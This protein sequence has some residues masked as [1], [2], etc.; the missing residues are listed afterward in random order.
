MVVP[1]NHEAAYNFSHFVN[2]YTMPN[3][4]DNHF[5]RLS[6]V[7]TFVKKCF[8]FDIDKV[9]FISFSTEFY[10]FKHYGSAQIARQYKWL[11]EDLKG[12]RNPA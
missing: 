5:Y 3:T 9:H 11:R 6:L 2:R 7:S 10:Y 8:S 4:T 1:G 12:R